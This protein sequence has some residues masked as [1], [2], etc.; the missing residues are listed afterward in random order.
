MESI[1]E[2]TG[3]QRSAMLLVTLGSEV[4]SRVMAHLDEKTVFKIA[5]EI[6]K[7]NDLTVKQKED[8]IGEFLIGYKKNK[9]AVYGGENI[10]KEMLIAAFGED[11]AENLLGNITHM[12]IEKGFLFLKNIDP[13]IITTLLEKEHPQTIT[14]AMYYL[15]PMQNAK[16]LKNFPA[17]LSKDII[18]RMAKIEKPS[19]GAVL[20]IVRILTNKYENLKKSAIKTEKTDGIN[21]LID[22]INQMNPEQGTKLMNYIDIKLPAISEKIKEKSFGFD[23][24]LNLT[25]RE[26]QI[27]IDELNDDFII[28]KALKGAGDALRFKF[29]RNMSQNRA[30][31]VLQ[32]MDNMGPVRLTE[33]NEARNSI[34]QIMRIL[35]DNGAITIKRERETFVD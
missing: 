17:E 12:D 13:E 2:I 27:L 8:L 32:E 15:S 34:M 10:A 6:V 31:I 26:I 5:Q 14:A 25:H 18:K 30:T 4:A 35:N 16:I 3:I 28:A 24:V 19:P 7:I 1:N 20:E 22:I 11:K 23:T 21:N 33:I 9:G 29:L